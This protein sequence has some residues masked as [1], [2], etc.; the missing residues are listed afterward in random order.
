MKKIKMGYKIAGILFAALV[1]ASCKKSS[2]PSPQLTL[3]NITDTIPE[4]GGTV[5]LKFTS[6][7]PWSV[8]TT[9]IGWLQLNQTS[10]NGGG[11]VINLTAAANSS[12]MSRSVLLN[13]SSANGQ[14]RRISVMQDAKIY[15]SY[16]ISPQAPDATGMNSTATQLVANIKM[17]YNIYNTME[18]PG[19]E[20]GWGN[21][22]ISQQLIN[23]IKNS[24]MNA[25]RIPV[26]YDMSHIINRATAKIDPAWLSRL[27]DVVQYCINDNM[28]AMVDIHWDGGWLDCT[29]TGAKQ[30]SINAK[31]KAYWEQIAT[32]LRDFDEH[33]MFASAN[34]PN[35]TDVPTSNVLMRYH[36][37]FINAVRSTGGKN[38]Y[39]TLIIQSPS[40]SID[41]A[42]EYLKSSNVFKVVPLP[43]DPTPNKMIL[44]FH[45]YT[46]SNFCILSADASWGKE[47]FFWGSSL[48]TKNP[49]FLDRNSAASTEERYVD[50]IFHTAKVNFV[51][52]GIPMI[53]GEYGTEYHAD[54]L[55]GYPTDS[56]LSVNSQMHF[57][58][59]VTQ[60]AKANG[61]LP[62]LW[63]SDVFNRQTNTIGNQ[64]TLDSLRKGAGF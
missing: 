26:Q 52:K 30:D 28:Y 38:N 33:L 1:T 22:V 35:A 18:A 58:R 11:A 5:A 45:Y 41:L 51:D 15:P 7:A 31:Q 10:G 63:A 9:G 43:V 23:L 55:K 12:G 40:T 24:G 32:T 3:G 25:V 59:Y 36:Q 50:S 47:S 49:L 19:D 16:N 42:N 37:T 39:R 27:K 34:E 48:H 14:S 44:E 60:Q 13:I 4:G 6:N 21:P 56:L 17:G 29:A 2:A 61:V 62:F 20:T 54:K 57:Y 64:R 53:M 46:P 8:D